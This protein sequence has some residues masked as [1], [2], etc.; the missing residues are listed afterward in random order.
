[1]FADLDESKIDGKFYDGGVWCNFMAVL[2]HKS[3]PWHEQKGEAMRSIIL[4]LGLA[5][6]LMAGNAAA[7]PVTVTGGFTFFDGPVGDGPR[8]TQTING[9]SVCATA[10]CNVAGNAHVDFHSP[11]GAVDFGLSD[12][13]VPDPA[14]RI[15]FTPASPQEVIGTGL[16]NK[17]LLGSMSYVNGNWFPPGANFG[18]TLTTHSTNPQ[19]DGKTFTDT[20]RMLITFNTSTDPVANAD[21]IYFAGNPLLGSARAYEL[22]DAPAGKDNTIRFDVYGHINSLHLDSFANPVG[23]FLDLSVGLQPASAVPEPSTILLLG[24]GLMGLTA[25]RA[26]RAG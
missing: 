13:G 20:L 22:F 25:W 3:H 18:F 16:S 7:T 24:A 5:A 4:A 23:G 11:V 1:L 14:N 8:I 15:S 17:F 19:F 21:F 26:K 10:G 2:F 9:N 12:S 6:C